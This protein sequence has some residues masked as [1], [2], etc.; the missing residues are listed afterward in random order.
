MRLDEEADF[1]ERFSH[2]QDQ[3]GGL[4]QRSHSWQCVGGT[5][6]HLSTILVSVPLPEAQ[7]VLPGTSAD[8]AVY[9]GAVVAHATVQIC[10]RCGLR[11]DK[12]EETE[13]T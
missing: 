6:K 8:L 7:L 10:P 1:E 12:D 3:A 5:T 13:S 9:D 4:V 11:V 2:L